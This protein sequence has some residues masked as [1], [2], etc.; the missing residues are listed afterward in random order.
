VP[1]KPFEV[2]GWSR[3]DEQARDPRDSTSQRAGQDNLCWLSTLSQFLLRVAFGGLVVALVPILAR[4]LNPEAAGV[5][6]LVPAITLVSFYFLGSDQ[7]ASA[8][9]RASST[10]IVTIPAVGAFLLGVNASLRRGAG[11]KLSLCLGLLAW[12]ALALPISFFT[13]ARGGQRA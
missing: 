3:L 1:N 6:V 12:L 8:V 13:R 9:I 2:V 11:L 7:G 4:L 5:L 10:S